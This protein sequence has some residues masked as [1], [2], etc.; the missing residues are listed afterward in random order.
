MKTNNK[1]K[2]LAIIK[3]W[4]TLMGFLLLLIVFSSLRPDVFPSGRNL[5]NI[6][7]QVATLAI[8]AS[9]VTV[10]MI[11]GDFDLS[12]GAIASLV[13]VVAALL[14]KS[15]VGTVVSISLAL[16]LGT[17]A[18]LLNGVLIAY[19]GLSAFVGTLATMTAYGGVALLISKGTTI[20]ALPENFRA[21]GQGSI[22]FLPI[23]VLIMAITVLVVYFLLEQTTYGRRLYAI[24]GNEEASFLSGIRTRQVRLIAFG[25]S[26]FFASLGGIVLTSRLF[27]AHP[28]AGSPFMLNAA[29]AVFL[30]MTSFREGEANILGTL[31]G[32]F[33]IGV[34]GNGLNIL[35]INTYVQ[36]ILTGAI[37]IFAVLLSSIAKKRQR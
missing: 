14:M 30:G 15:G 37:I 18:G 8:V 1:T 10:V 9:G 31:L 26:G 12:V 24:G 35:G 21:L 29:A 13:G 6:I 20:F 27:S 2:V 25:V 16:L 5:K 34:M 36:S 22:G 4:G 32:V 23:S 33:I 28:Q 17:S 11:T 3:T 7:E 19:G